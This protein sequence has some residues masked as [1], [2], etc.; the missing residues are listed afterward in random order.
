MTEDQELPDHVI[1]EMKRTI[2]I[3]LN[4]YDHEELDPPEWI[5][6]LDRDILAIL[7]R[8]MMVL[9]PSV[10]A[11]NIDRSRSSV[12]RRLNTL[13]VGGLVEKEERGHYKISSEGHARMYQ[14]YPAEVEDRGSDGERWVTFGIPTSEEMKIIKE[15]SE[16][17]DLE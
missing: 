8:T 1:E 15:V 6:E 2:D 13:E 4:E 16:E 12:S 3:D 11:K 5:T 10:I 7:G 14:K 17:S 9:T